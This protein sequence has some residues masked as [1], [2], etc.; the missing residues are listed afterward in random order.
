MD[1]KQIVEAMGGVKET[2]KITG[3][4]RGRIY[5]FMKENHIPRPWLLFFHAKNPKKIPLPKN[6]QQ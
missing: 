2:V 5:Q 4:T 3:L 1:A 6:Q